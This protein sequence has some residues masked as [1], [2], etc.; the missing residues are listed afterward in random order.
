MAS[1]RAKAASCRMGDAAAKLV[2][3]MLL[4]WHRTAARLAADAAAAPEQWA[5]SI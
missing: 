2:R 1:D 5:G 3:Q 4:W